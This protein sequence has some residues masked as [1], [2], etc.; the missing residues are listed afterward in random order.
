MQL[1][2]I[3]KI[4]VI[5]AGLM[6]HGIAQEFALAGYTVAIHDI[7]DEVIAQAREK[8]QAN[9][10]RLIGFGLVTEEQAAPVPDLI[11]GSTNLKEVAGDA[12]LVIEAVSENLDLKQRIF[13]QLDVIC[14]ERTILASNTST[15]MPSK[16]ASATQR[17]D[18]VLI[19]HY[20]NPPYLIPL[21]EVVRH[22]GTSDASVEVVTALLKKVG[23]SPAV[24]NRECP[25]FIV[26][27]LQV[28]LLREALSIVDN[29]IASAEDVDTVIKSSIGRRWAAAGVFEVF[30]IAGWDVIINVTRNLLADIESSRDLSP[31]ISDKVE[32]GDYGTKTG[33]GFYDY[34]PETAEQLTKRIQQVLV[35]V[36]QLA[37][38]E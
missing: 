13:A 24:L 12:D 21:V 27:R 23:K 2:D 31:L 17:P 29:G 20:V 36:E 15:L 28:A 38:K 26:N 34:T 30:D 4:A 19:V 9:L 14:P 10:K 16:L 18:R 11:H 33:K 7:N 35:A 6:G 37:R 3:K 5:G 22:P 1:E 25:G 8:V 32:R